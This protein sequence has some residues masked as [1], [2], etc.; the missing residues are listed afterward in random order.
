MTYNY[1]I[2][3]PHPPAL[4]ERQNAAA[5]VKVFIHKLVLSVERLC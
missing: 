2:V 4:P 5:G 3:V 1:P